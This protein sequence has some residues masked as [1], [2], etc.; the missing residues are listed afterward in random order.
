[1]S[2]SYDA[3]VAAIADAE[4]LP[5]SADELAALTATAATMRA[6]GEQFARLLGGSV[7]QDR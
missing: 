6:H 2:T 4:G 7:S 3:L 1:M 5:C